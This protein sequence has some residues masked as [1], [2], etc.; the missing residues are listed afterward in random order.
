METVEVEGISLT[1]VHDETLCAHRHC[2]IH[3]PSDHHMR[4]WPLHW[5]DDR[6]IFERIDAIGCGHPDPDQFGYWQETGQDGMAVHGCTGLC[7]KE[8]WNEYVASKT[9]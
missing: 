9:E 1:N 6:G 3:N 4:S 7:D 5:R 8:R 2:V